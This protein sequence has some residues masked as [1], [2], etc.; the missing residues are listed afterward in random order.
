MSVYSNIRTYIHTY[1]GVIIQWKQHDKHVDV[2][3]S[4]L[5]LAACIS[6]N[7][8]LHKQWVLETVYMWS[9]V[10]HV[11]I[12]YPYFSFQQLLFIS[13]IAFMLNDI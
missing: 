3:V 12:L 11:T 1:N 10:S 4:C 13:T 5:Q 2:L 9:D 7:A 8:R 6:G